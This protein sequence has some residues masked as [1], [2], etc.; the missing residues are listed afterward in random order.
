M[1]LLTSQQLA[2]RLQ[3]RTAK[4]AAR[5]ARERLRLQPYSLGRGRGMGDRWDWREVEDAL[6]AMRAGKPAKKRMPKVG[7]LTG[8]PVAD[9]IQ[10]LTRAHPKH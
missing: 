5:F 10:E 8:R 3:L 1:I 2:E 6:E 4:T 7:H 9:I